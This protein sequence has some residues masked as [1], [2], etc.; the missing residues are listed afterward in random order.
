LDGV[1]KLVEIATGIDIFAD[2]RNQAQ[3]RTL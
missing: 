3:P 1:S 2:R